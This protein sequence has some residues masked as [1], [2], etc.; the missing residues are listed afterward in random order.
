[1][2]YLMDTNIF[3][4]AKNSYYAFDL[5]P[6][7]W[8]WL[9]QCDK[10]KSVAMVKDELLKG[11]D[12]LTEWVKTQLD[13]DFFIDADI[14]IQHNYRKVANYVFNL[15]NF[16]HAEKQRFLAGADG[17]LI[18]TAMSRKDIIITHESNDIKSKRTIFLPVIADQFGV[19]CQTIFNVLKTFH[20]VF[21]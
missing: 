4:E 10:V 2:S 19:H 12:E 3:I 13:D 9:R 18:A 15:S 16:K 7:F 11:N 14:D 21:R 1:M 6:G 20:V 5:C 17:W 8:K